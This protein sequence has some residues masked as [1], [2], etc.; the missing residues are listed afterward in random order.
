MRLRG[1]VPGF[2]IENLEVSI[3]GDIL[4][5]SGK[6]EALGEFERS[7]QLPFPVDADKVKATAKDGV[8]EI[9]LPRA[10]ADAARRI[11]VQAG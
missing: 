8:L 2:A 3:S 6:R 10:A 11:Q 9:E 1:L 5:V 4:T 7:F